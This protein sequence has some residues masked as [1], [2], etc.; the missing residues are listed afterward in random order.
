MECDFSGYAT[1]A[2]LKCTDG[3]TIMPGAFRHQDQQRVPLVWQ[4]GHND[5]ENVLGHA[6]LEERAD[7]VYA[8]GFFN[9][10]PKA[11]HAH[12]LLEHRDITQMSIWANELVQRAG[13]VLHGAIREVSL[14][15]AGANPGALIENVSIR[16]SDGDVD[17]LDD[18]AI[19][20]TGLELEHQAFSHADNSGDGGN[21]GK[22]NDDDN[23][24]D[25]EN[26]DDGEKT[27]ED[28]YESMS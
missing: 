8:Y 27:I 25:D 14:V 3:R 5:P 6:V 11:K 22:D 26:D 2:G 9:D 16:H 24:D 12:G 13:K 7:G 10:S 23:N 15:L 19:I 1:K 28:V 17:T 18:E 20:Y 4:H 21:T